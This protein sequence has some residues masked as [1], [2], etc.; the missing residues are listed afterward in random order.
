M[1]RFERIQD[2]L[3]TVGPRSTRQIGEYFGW[4]RT[5]ASAVISHARTYGYIEAIDSIPVC[6]NGSGSPMLIWRH[7]E[8]IIRYPSETRVQR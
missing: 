5:T 3:R 1:T 6:P 8:E 4:S 7:R 2:H